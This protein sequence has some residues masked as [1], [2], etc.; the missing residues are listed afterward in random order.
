MKF[1]LLIT[2]LL[3]SISLHNNN[4]SYRA[5]SSHAFQELAT[6]KNNSTCSLQNICASSKSE[7][8]DW[9]GS[10]KN[11]KENWPNG[12]TKAELARALI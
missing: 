10:N 2:T 9:I 1:F 3:V 8:K 6:A 11:W 5:A 7:K 12:R 4:S